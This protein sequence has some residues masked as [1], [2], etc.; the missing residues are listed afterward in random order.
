MGGFSDIDWTD[1]FHQFNRLLGAV[2]G[3]GP[4]LQAMEHQGLTDQILKE[5]TL[6]SPLAVNLYNRPRF[7]KTLDVETRPYT[8]G[9]PL[10]DADV[11][12][13]NFYGVDPTTINPSQLP[14][15]L[16]PAV[17]TEDL[18]KIML[19]SGQSGGGLL[20]ELARQLGF[21]P[22]QVQVDPSTGKGRV[23]FS[24]PSTK[25]VPP[26]ALA[27]QEGGTTGQAQVAPTGQGQVT[28]LPAS[29]TVRKVAAGIRPVPRGFVPG[30]EVPTDTGTA[31]ATGVPGA[32][33]TQQAAGAPGA[34]PPAPGAQPA[35]PGA[36]GAAPRVPTRVAE[37]PRDLRT[38]GRPAPA[39]SPA[40]VP[41]PELDNAWTTLGV[42]GPRPGTPGAAAAATPPQPRGAPPVVTPAP[43]TGAG[44]APVAAPAT[45]AV[46][47]VG[48]PPARRQ[49][50]GSVTQVEQERPRTPEGKIL[51]A[52]RT[53]PEIDRRVMEAGNG[54]SELAL[55]NDPTLYADVE[56]ARRSGKYLE[57]AAE[58]GLETDVITKRIVNSAKAALVRVDDNYGPSK[59]PTGEVYIN[60]ETGQPYTYRDVLTKNRVLSSI[61]HYLPQGANVDLVYNIVNNPD[62]PEGLRIAARH[63]LESE[64]IRPSLAKAMG[65]VGNLNTMEQTVFDSYIIKGTDSVV[66]AQDKEN[67][68]RSMLTKTIA[69]LEGGK[70]K[71]LDAINDFRRQLGLPP[72]DH[73]M[74]QQELDKLD[75]DEIR[76]RQGLGGQQ[77]VGQPQINE[78]EQ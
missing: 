4:R 19:Q 11:A 24:P 78:G 5:A 45:P 49:T 25:A 30:M 42:T 27:G 54:D 37:Q 52:M 35:A 7:A 72:R 55:R 2:T 41:N 14:L 62:A 6:Q 21:D 9:T 22:S 34:P 8:S 77:D 75:Q 39:P 32:P 36:P 38:A 31:P 61:G 51:D 28:E 44:G 53:D 64:T 12:R 59:S 67:T 10:S 57:K 68:L 47:P 13:L 70:Q 23:L 1:K 3:V 43:S 48:P 15:N 40:A 33:P 73:I 74:S 16:P 50:R 60:P 46:R 63:V 66:G 20:T 76:R 69:T 18:A 29:Q 71:P 65:E 58:K 26:G 56:A 17:M